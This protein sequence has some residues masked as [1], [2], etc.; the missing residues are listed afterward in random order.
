M[1]L[2][3]VTIQAISP[4]ALGRCSRMQCVCN[5]VAGEVGKGV[6]EEEEKEKEEEQD[7]NEVNPEYD[8]P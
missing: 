6:E 8:K 3:M 2:H 4:L 5:P 1:Q 7:E